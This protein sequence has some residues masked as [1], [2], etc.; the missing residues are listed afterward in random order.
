MDTPLPESAIHPLIHHHTGPITTIRRTTHGNT[1]DLTAVIDCANG[2]FFVKAVR[3]RPGGRRDSLLR[4]RQ[5]APTLLDLSPPL[6][7]D[8]EGDGWLVLGYE[9]VEA[10]HADLTPGS[11][12]LPLVVDTVARIGRVPLPAYAHSWTETRW[13]RF[14]PD[15]ALLRGDALL[16]TDINPHNLLVAGPR[17]WAVDWAWPTRGAAFIDPALLVVQLIAAGHTPASAEGWASRIPTWRTAD[18]H[19]VTVF[20]AATLRMHEAFAARKPDEE[21]LKAMVEAC[22]SW[23]AYGEATA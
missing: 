23:T 1:S 9:A 10:R 13:D 12:D 3:D 14:T 22:R 6:L 17:V 11:P 4:E 19:A 16:H 8:V 7:W 15:A 21:W 5:V 2:P 20:A 18:R